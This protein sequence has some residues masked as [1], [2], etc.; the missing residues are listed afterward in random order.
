[1]SEEMKYVRLAGIGF[2][3]WPKC[4]DIWHKH[5]GRFGRVLSAGFAHI[6]G[7]GVVYCHGRSESL[8]IG[9]L[10]DDSKAL[11]LQLGLKD[12]A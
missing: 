1:M 12:D 7:K 9:G 6:D 5:I 3:L 11:A 10:P 4:D 8:G 2:V